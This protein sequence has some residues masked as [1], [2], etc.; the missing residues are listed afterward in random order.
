M[1]TSPSTSTEVA[2]R[3]LYVAQAGETVG[4]ARER[5]RGDSVTSWD[6]VAEEVD[7]S[8]HVYR[9][10]LDLLALLG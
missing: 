2:R 9:S 7:V 8:A 4:A 6:A 10:A 3:L 5:Y 1:R